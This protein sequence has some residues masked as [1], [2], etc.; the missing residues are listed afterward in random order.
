MAIHYQQRRLKSKGHMT[1][2]NPEVLF[3][4]SS[5]LSW[6]IPLAHW[7]NV[8]IKYMNNNIKYVEE[9]VQIN[10]SHAG[11]FVGKMCSRL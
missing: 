8:P 9:R 7:P 11:C 5:F 2:Q 6:K 4:Y 10:T 1:E 3:F